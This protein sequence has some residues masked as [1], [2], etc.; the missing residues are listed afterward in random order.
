[1]RIS[2]I[3]LAFCLVAFSS[4]AQ[5]N[6]FAVRDALR[7]VESNPEA[8]I[9]DLRQIKSADAKVA[10]AIALHF[11]EPSLRKPNG[12]ISSLLSFLHDS[13]P[14]L[15]VSELP[16]L[17]RILLTSSAGEKFAVAYDGST[18]ALIR[19]LQLSSY[20]LSLN[21][22][23]RRLTIPCA[24]FLAHPEIGDIRTPVATTNTLWGDTRIDCSEEFSERLSFTHEYLRDYRKVTFGFS[25]CR[26]GTLSSWQAGPRETRR[27]SMLFFPKALIRRAAKQNSQ[28][29]R[30]RTSNWSY[31]S[32]WNYRYFSDLADTRA[33]AQE[34]LVEYY[35]KVFGF[36]PSLAEKASE[37]ALPNLRG[38]FTRLQSPSQLRKEIMDGLPITKKYLSEL[39]EIIDNEHRFTGAGVPDPI[40][41]I[42]V[43]RSDVLSEL[44]INGVDPDQANFFGKTPLMA[45]SQA[46]ELESVSVLIKAGANINIQLLSA[47]SI[48][49]KPQNAGGGCLSYT[50]Q[51][52]ERTALM[53]AAAEASKVVIT[54]LLDNGARTDIK[55][56]QG[57]TAL[58]Y[59]L[60]NG[61]V[62]PNPNLTEDELVELK[63]LL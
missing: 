6:V 47:E 42:S 63:S 34:E 51:H 38:Y 53:Y 37:N 61:P 5:E 60:G 40:S 43:L 11:Y 23:P 4:E 31:L 2:A 28:S 49:L 52:G 45:A 58:D 32:L 35:T 22:P 1:M 14:E 57:L 17:E 24:L 10:L 3:L 13:L 55:D 7:L 44:L 59:M 26:G 39:S 29:G 21:R 62:P 41:H 8:A 16:G 46:N 19:N 54:E 25:G 9:T 20:Y 18:N 33:K 50:I 30:P 12:E 27:L 48:K 15:L 56:S 36:L